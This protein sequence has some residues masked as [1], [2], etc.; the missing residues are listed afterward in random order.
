M[1]PNNK[2]SSKYLD[3]SNFPLYPFGYGLSY[4]TFAYG[5]VKVDNTMLKGDVTLTAT[6]KV[7]NTGRYAGE[8]TVQLYIQDLVASIS[9]PVKE[10]KDFR[11][12]LLQPGESKEVTFD[13]TT[14]DLKFYNSDLK[15]DWESGDFMIHAGSNSR[16]V[17]SVKVNWVK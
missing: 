16:D 4:T 11:K 3:I 7:T 15:Y 1:D 9:R 12:I 8:E 13:I 10:L 2:F 6:I 14:D 17:K 5:D